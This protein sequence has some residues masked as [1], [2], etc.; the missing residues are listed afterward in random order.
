MKKIFWRIIEL[1]T[2]SI[3]FVYQSLFKPIFFTKIEWKWILN[4]AE[5]ETMYKRF[6]ISGKIDF[7]ITYEDFIKALRLSKSN[8]RFKEYG[9]SYIIPNDK[10]FFTAINNINPKSRN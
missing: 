10:A 8:P 4:E 7:H 2:R 9:K 6:Y 1:S 3:I 5:L